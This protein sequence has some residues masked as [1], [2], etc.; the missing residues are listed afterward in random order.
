MIA[1]RD[2]GILV[3]LFLLNVQFKCVPPNFLETQ[4][5]GGGGHFEGTE[6]TAN[7]KNMNKIKTKQGV[8]A[9]C[10]CNLV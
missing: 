9:F 8:I 5:T 6:V 2:F 7:Q 3:A 1:L 10:V 4:T